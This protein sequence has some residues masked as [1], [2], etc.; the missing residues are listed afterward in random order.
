MIEIAK[1]VPTHFSK[2]FIHWSKI[3]MYTNPIPDLRSLFILTRIAVIQSHKIIT[4]SKTTKY[5]FIQKS[6][7]Y[8]AN[9]A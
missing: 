1:T 2:S 7:D 8:E 5:Y 9:L 4:F 6:T 3:K